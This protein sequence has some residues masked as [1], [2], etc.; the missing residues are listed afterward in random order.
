MYEDVLAPELAVLEDFSTRL[1]D[2]LLDHVRGL[3][4]GVEQATRLLSY[5]THVAAKEIALELKIN[6]KI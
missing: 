2:V 3:H 5:W 6:F 4:V 1:T